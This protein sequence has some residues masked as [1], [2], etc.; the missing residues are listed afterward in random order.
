MQEKQERQDPCSNE[1][2]NLLEEKHILKQTDED[3]FR[4]EKVLRRK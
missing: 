4:L 2:C 3:N 1:D